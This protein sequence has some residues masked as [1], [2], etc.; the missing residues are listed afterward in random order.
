MSAYVLDSNFIIRASYQHTAEHDFLIKIIDADSQLYVPT[1]V[2]AEALT[3]AN[4]AEQEQ[5]EAL[6]AIAM[7]KNC[8]LVIAKKAAEL[9]ALSLKKRKVYLLDCIIAATAELEEA[10]LVS[11]NVADYKSLPIKIRNFT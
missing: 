7:V 4:Q 11:N 10:V 9:R 3:K 5:L 8:D 6:L 2:V 1:V